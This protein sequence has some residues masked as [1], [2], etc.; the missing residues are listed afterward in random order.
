[1]SAPLEAD[2]DD[3]SITKAMP[4]VSSLVSQA[5]YSASPGSSTFMRL[6]SND[7]SL[8]NPSLTTNS[9]S[10]AQ[11][12]KVSY[13]RIRAQ[14]PSPDIVDTLLKYFFCN[15]Y[16]TS[17]VIDENHLQNLLHQWL[18]TPIEEYIAASPNSAQAEL[19]HFPALLF[20]VLAQILHNLSPQHPAARA[21]EL[22]DY[23]DCDRLSQTYYSLGCKLEALLSHQH[24]T[25]CSVEHDIASGAWLKDSSRG[26]EAWHQLGN[27]V[28]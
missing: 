20:Q 22:S 8:G 10:S 14:L 4:F 13:L 15:V 6:K 12:L 9:S 7:L 27:A 25:L 1:M 2:E 11:G 18:A 19:L 26:A 5:G 17:V 16:W 23:H 21:L 28:R 24:L 3:S